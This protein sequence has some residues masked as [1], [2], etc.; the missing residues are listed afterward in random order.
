M[1]GL[2]GCDPDV[3]VGDEALVMLGGVAVRGRAVGTGGCG[4]SEGGEGG[5][6]LEVGGEKEER[7]ADGGVVQDGGGGVEGGRCLRLVR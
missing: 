4:A 7:C 2:L 3:Y 1:G 6:G 5:V